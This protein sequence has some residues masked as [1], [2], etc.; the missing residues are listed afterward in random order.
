MAHLFL[1]LCLSDKSQLDAVCVNFAW[2]TVGYVCV[3]VCVYV[4]NKHCLAFCYE[5]QVGQMK[6]LIFWGS[7][8]KVRTRVSVRLGLI[9]LHTEVS[10]AQTRPCVL[11]AAVS[12][13]RA[14]VLSHLVTWSCACA[15]LRGS[16]C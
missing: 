11:S 3:C 10:R 16:A 13:P 5:M 15:T 4:F 9:I 12:L 6:S 7:A 14:C 2:L 8:P 1:L